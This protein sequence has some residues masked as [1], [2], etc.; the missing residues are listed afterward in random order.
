MKKIVL[1]ALT[2]L[3]MAG[4]VKTKED[5]EPIISD[6][7]N[8]HS[9]DNPYRQVLDSCEYIRWNGSMAHKGNCHFCEQRDSI[10]WEK[11]RK[12]LE[13]LVVKLKEK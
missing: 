5:G 3:M 4:C 10:K 12:E 6:Y 8:Q 9:P 1:L 13:E 2:A 7:Y 11:R